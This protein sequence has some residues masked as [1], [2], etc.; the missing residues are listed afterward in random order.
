[1]PNNNRNKKLILG[2]NETP[3]PISMIQLSIQYLMPNMV[4]LLFIILIL[5]QANVSANNAASILSITM[6]IMSIVNILQALRIPWISPGMLLPPS[7]APPYIAPCMLAIKTG[8]L[9]LVFGMTII[10]GIMQCAL[11]FFVR[12]IRRFVPEEIAALVLLLIGFE[13]GL[14]GIQFYLNLSPHFIS[15]TVSFWAQA[16]AY[17]P[18]LL[19]IIFDELGN[20]ILKKYSL[21]ITVVITYLLIF[22]T[23]HMNQ[24]HISD[25]ANASWV[26]F[27]HLF[28]GDYHFSGDLVVPF[29]LA[30]II[31]AVKLI[32]SVFALEE[33]QVEEPESVDFKRI[34]KANFIDGLGSLL[35][36]VFGSMGMNVSSSS[37]A[38]S[39]STRI[40]S[41]YIAIPLSIIFLLL[42]FIPKF[43]LLLLHI[44]SA[45]MAA[46]LINL[47]V[48]LVKS[49]C[50]ILVKRLVHF[51]AHLA[52]GIAFVAG[53]SYSVY[54]EIYK[55]LSTEVKMFVGST[56]A[57]SMIVAVILSFALSFVK[58]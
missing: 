49:S 12:Y 54:P 16:L 23:G 46:I 32:G 44:P 17:L 40:T 29:I 5:Q 2:F 22:F 31:C 28:I 57:I 35:G 20:S 56:I 8:G 48:K 42:A 13:L 30:A 38:L 18:L 21:I 15:S 14:Y 47:G 45:I 7:I 27:P 36:G 19:V 52:I 26:F 33:L 43:E 51:H 25:I 24:Q 1:M 3:L 50:I 4:S 9:S 11:S 41:R 6:I 58:K 34:A 10:G 37:I 55:S 39:L 53:I